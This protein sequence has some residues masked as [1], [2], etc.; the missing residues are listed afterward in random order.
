MDDELAAAKGFDRLRAKQPVRIGYQ[1]DGE[2]ARQ[3]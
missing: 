2:R 1:A 3:R